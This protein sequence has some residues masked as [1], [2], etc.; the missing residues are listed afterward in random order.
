[1]DENILRLTMDESRMFRITGISRNTC[2]LFYP[3]RP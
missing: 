2:I 3:D 1:M